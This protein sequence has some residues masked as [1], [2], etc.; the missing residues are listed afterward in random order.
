MRSI[1]APRSASSAFWADHVL[2]AGLWTSLYALVVEIWRKGAEVGHGSRYLYPTSRHLLDAGGKQEDPSP[3]LRASLGGTARPWAIHDRVDQHRPDCISIFRNSTEPPPARLL[4][5]GVREPNFIFHL[6]PCPPLVL[7][8]SSGPVHCARGC[9]S[10]NPSDSM[11]SFTPPAQSHRKSG[12]G[13]D[14]A[15]RDGDD[16]QILLD[17]RVGHGECLH[18][19]RK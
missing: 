4:L 19:L 18:Q 3:E 7:R 1:A 9:L 12:K 6:F 10:A 8:C 5:P 16:R 15:R 2:P 14:S 13:C 17:T 11:F